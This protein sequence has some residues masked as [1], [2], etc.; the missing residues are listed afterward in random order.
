[1][2]YESLFILFSDAKKTR[3]KEDRMGNF[4]IKV[5][6]RIGLKALFV[7]LTSTILC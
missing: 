5:A 3:L 1:M 7:R 6:P 2:E 4:K